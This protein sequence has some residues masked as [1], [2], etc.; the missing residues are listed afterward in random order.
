[1]TGLLLDARSALRSLR[2]SP[3]FAG[4][5]L[6]TL[7][8]ALG[9]N[10]A[11]LGVARTVFTGALPFEDGENVVRLRDFT[12][13]A[14]GVQRPVNMS[15]RNF[16]AI[17]ESG[18]FAGVVA[19]RGRSATLL[20]QGSPERLQ[21][22]DVSPGWADV[23]GLDAEFGRTFTAGEE[24]EGA[25]A[26]VLL[27][28]DP[29]FRTRF[30]ADPSVIGSEVVVGDVAHTVIGVMP[31]GFRFPYSADAWTPFVPDESVAGH[32]LNVLAR[33]R[34]GE[35]RARA[36]QIMTRLA[37]SLALTHPETNHDWGIVVEDARENFVQ[38]DD[39]L[40][41]ALSLAVS[42]V[43]VLAA[44][45]V[46]NLLI[47]RLLARRREIGI[48]AALGAT[49]WQ[50]MRPLVLESVVL[51]A[52]G[53]MSGLLLMLWTRQWLSVLIPRVLREQLNLGT[54]LLDTP[55][56][57]ATL[58]ASVMGGL[59][60]GAIAAWRGARIDA[61]SVLREGRGGG[62]R[63]RR[64]LQRTLVLAQLSLAVMLLAGAGTLLRH[65]QALR[66]ADPGFDVDGL[67][68][69]R[70][71]LDPQLEP[72]DR[73][74]Q[75]GTLLDEV[76][77]VP[78]IAAAGITTVNP[79]CCGDWGAP[80]T[81]EHRP[82]AA[83]GSRIVV[84]HR[85]ITPG[86]LDAMGIP[87]EAG[88]DFT[89]ADNANALPVVIVDR[90]MAEH[91][92]PGEDPIGRRVKLGGPADPAPWHTV[93]GVAGTV[94]D[95][96]DYVDTWYLPYAQTAFGPLGQLLHVM[97]RTRGDASAALGGL[98]TA[99]ARANPA[100]AVY[101]ERAMPEI[102]A[103]S[104]ADERMGMTVLLLF[105]AFGLAL[106]AIGLYGLIAYFV[107]ERSR[108]IGTRVALGARQLDVLWL[109]LR[110][111][112]LPLG[113]GAALGIAGAVALV[114]LLGSIVPDL[115]PVDATL[116][117]GSLVLLAAVSAL[118]TARPALRAARTKPMGVLRE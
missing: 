74:A 37:A 54:V 61:G 79:L 105:A 4:V 35:T 42:L 60:I 67:Y 36:Q 45:N 53:G 49:A 23:L 76:R 89:T 87:L 84:H 31:A 19:Q 12:V 28:S 44:V 14:D 17:L 62:G 112:A 30:G 92:W 38:Q 16:V 25:A 114:R 59:M 99:I 75:V 1:M 98:R 116:L 32:S 41:L 118:A 73:I 77:S 27:L 88:R 93:I 109:V 55:L 95:A 68:T 21:I 69:A 6:L 39:R 46:A 106:A 64:I 86:L 51:F 15:A 72:A 52:M 110:Q 26:G 97:V 5:A 81:I 91:F 108:E 70:A 20:A 113:A 78:G 3:G 43:L 8:I 96:G 57:V 101:G 104:L 107:G 9:G 7:A 115:P 40:V 65:V 63:E 56:I 2:R 111:A 90:R 13:G 24:R 94:D 103:E 80:V 29:F 102:Q 85:M 66:T 117:I 82:A 18:A 58:V 48:R 11:V 10:T 22:V 71:D 100:L 47:A 83:D 50:R 34:A 33:L